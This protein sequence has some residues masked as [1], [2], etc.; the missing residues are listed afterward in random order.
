MLSANTRKVVSSNDWRPKY[1]LAI[2]MRHPSGDQCS[3]WPPDRARC[4]IWSRLGWS[5]YHWYED[6][7]AITAVPNEPRVNMCSSLACDQRLEI[8]TSHSGLAV[9]HKTIVNLFL[10][11]HSTLVLMSYCNIGS[12]LL[13]HFTDHLQVALRQPSHYPVLLF[14]AFCQTNRPFPV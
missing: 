11:I 12:C 1:R 3:R 5:W 10:F 2:D 13:W 9:L 8:R 4:Q 6:A 14:I 7:A